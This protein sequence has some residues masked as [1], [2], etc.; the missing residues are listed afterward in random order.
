MAIDSF[1]REVENAG[2]FAIY[3]LMD[4]GMASYD[5]SEGRH[6][7]A[8]MSIDTLIVF[9]TRGKM[10]LMEQAAIISSMTM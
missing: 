9:C 5:D 8:P 6:Y 7:E 1:R 3:T 4:N 2:A 10:S